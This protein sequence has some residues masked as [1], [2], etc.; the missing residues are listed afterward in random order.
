MRFRV[1]LQRILRRSIRISRCRHSSRSSRCIRISINRLWS[2]KRLRHRSRPII[3]RSN[4]AIIVLRMRCNFSNLRSRDSLPMNLQRRTIRLRLRMINHRLRIITNSKRIITAMATTMEAT[5]PPP[6][7]TRV[8]LHRRKTSIHGI[9]RPDSNEC[10]SNKERIDIKRINN[11]TT[12]TMRKARRIYRLCR[13]SRCRKLRIITLILIIT[14]RH[15]MHRVHTQ[16]LVRSRRKKIND[17]NSSNNNCN[18][19]SSNRCCHH[20]HSHRSRR[21]RIHNRSMC[22]I[23]RVAAI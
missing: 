10:G 20:S 2:N 14:H 11:R 9:L 19:S 7:T 21:Q 22:R 15:K 13:N 4:S 8:D 23:L 6:I 18:N 16:R 3:Q 5:H 12:T 17:K 1:C